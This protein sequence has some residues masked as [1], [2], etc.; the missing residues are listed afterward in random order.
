[1]PNA[2]APNGFKPVK[3]ASGGTPVRVG[4]YT[5]S[6]AY[7]TALFEGDVVK[8]DGSGNVN[9]AAAGDAM[10]GVFKGCQYTAPDGSVVFKN[11]WV[12][13]T[14]TKS[15]TVRSAYVYDDP[16][17]VFEAQ[18]DGTMTAADKGQLCNIDVSQ[19][20][21]AATGISRQQTSATGGSE[22]Q[23][24]VVGVYG[25]GVND[26]VARDSSGNHAALAT[27]LNARVLVKPAKHELGGSAT[28]VEV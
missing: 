19:A 18:S 15:G 22:S 17:M 4:T 13:S 8:T 3:H 24:V 21:D 25:D 5:I 10:I 26:K 1:M 9:I 12:A 20:G 27:G 7:A 2:D 11:N 14:A 28:A 16:N 6:S 23:F